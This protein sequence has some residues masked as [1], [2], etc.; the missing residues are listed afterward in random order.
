MAVEKA[1]KETQQAVLKQ[2]LAGVERDLKQA[3]AFDPARTRVV[4][5]T[6][7]ILARRSAELQTR[8]TNLQPPTVTMI[9]AN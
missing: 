7:D 4:R 2:Q 5:E 9:G 1:A 3:A 6:L 8:I